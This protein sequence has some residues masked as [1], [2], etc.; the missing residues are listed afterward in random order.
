MTQMAGCESLEIFDELVD[1]V[2]EDA[3]KGNFF[4]GFAKKLRKNVEARLKAPRVIPKYVKTN[5]IESSNGRC[6]VY[7]EHTPR[8][9]PDVAFL[10]KQMVANTKDYMI[11]ALYQEGPWA[12]APGSKL[13][14][15]SKTAWKLKSK[16]A[17]D[18]YFLRAICGKSLV[19]K[20]PDLNNLPGVT[21][22]EKRK[23]EEHHAEAIS[24]HNQEKKRKLKTES[25]KADNIQLNLSSHIKSKQHQRQR[26]SAH[27]TRPH[28]PGLTKYNED[29]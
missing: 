25:K 10:L 19:P 22:A 6:K 14:A 1:N 29:I 17:Q 15:I 9:I 20:M 27:K 13:K 8:T 23:A 7:T 2:P 3:F 21:A 26:A 12:I 4:E 24:L 11:Q 28:R 5:Y 16:K 18:R